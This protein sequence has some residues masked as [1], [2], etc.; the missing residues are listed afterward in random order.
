MIKILLF[1]KPGCPNCE[2]QKEVFEG[3]LYD[4]EWEYIDITKRQEDVEVKI[5]Y[6][7][8]GES[9]PHII[10]EDEDHEILFSY[11]GMLA[12]K[13]VVEAVGNAKRKSQRN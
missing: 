10:I 12:P 3:R 6:Y 1:G 13:K 9:L 5:D 4:V 2:K 11:N 7:E 8:I